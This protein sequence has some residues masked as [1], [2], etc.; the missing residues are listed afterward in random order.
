MATI[1]IGQQQIVVAPATQEPGLWLSAADLDRA[2]GFTLK[3]EGLC[4]EALCVPVPRGGK[5]FVA[6]G[7]VNA[8]AFWRH[9]GNL[10]VHD[11]TSDVWAFGE[12]AGAR[13]QALETMVAPE[14]SLPDIHGR[15]HSLSEQRGRKVFLATW[16]SW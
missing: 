15:I 2:T 7:N 9:I 4:K 10:V 1:L 11:E 3:P 14:L 16:A 12:G 8:E 5:S 13:T 6:N